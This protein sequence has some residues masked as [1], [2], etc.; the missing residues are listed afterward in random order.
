MSSEDEDS[1]KEKQPRGESQETPNVESRDGKA[2]ETVN[3]Y[4]PS[5]PAE[6]EAMPR[7]GFLKTLG[8]NA[9]YFA[10]GAYLTDT[11]NAGNRALERDPKDADMNRKM[12]TGGGIVGGAAGVWIGNFMEKQNRKHKDRDN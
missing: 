2:P 6:E 9:A 1:G 8:K 12:R 3:P 7:R 4:Q 10:G 5:A 11:V